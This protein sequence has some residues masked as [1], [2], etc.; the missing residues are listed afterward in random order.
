MLLQ[1][2]LLIFLS[3]FS[4]ILLRKFPSCFIGISCTLRKSTLLRGHLISILAQIFRLYFRQP[5]TLFA[6]LWGHVAFSLFLLQSILHGILHLWLHI[7]KQIQNS[8]DPLVSATNHPLDLYLHLHHVC[9]DLIIQRCRN[10]SSR[11][12]VLNSESFVKDRSSLQQRYDQVNNL[13][14]FLGSQPFMV[15]HESFALMFQSVVKF[16]ETYFH[17][18]GRL[19]K[20]IITYCR[21]MSFPRKRSRSLSIAASARWV[22]SWLFNF[23]L[24]NRSRN[25]RAI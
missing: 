19:N 9:F 10:Q 8:L 17:Q 16:G 3:K 13:C 23:N 21:N 24:A 1:K 11:G 2:L 22:K 18:L 7:G 4:V 14:S 15:R 12:F 5:E 6:G 25:S 20:R